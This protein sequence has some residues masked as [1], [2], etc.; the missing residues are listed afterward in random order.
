MLKVGMKH[1]AY[2]L[3]VVR[4]LFDWTIMSYLRHP[5]FFPENVAHLVETWRTGPQ[6]TNKKGPQ[7]QI[8]H[9]AFAP[10]HLKKKPS[11]VG[12]NNFLSY[13]HY[14]SQPLCQLQLEKKYLSSMSRLI[15]KWIPPKQW[16]IE[17]NGCRFTRWFLLPFNEFFL[18]KNLAQDSHPVNS[19]VVIFLAAASPWVNPN[20]P[21]TPPWHNVGM[22]FP[23]AQGGGRW[24]LEVRSC[25]FFFGGWSLK[26]SGANCGKFYGGY[27]YQ[28]LFWGN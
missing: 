13:L 24:K 20:R 10:C 5:V 22:E 15:S 27:R 18:Q 28:E 3:D 2:W 14:I 21:E 23:R 17:K 26:F 12:C 1:I 11:I 7:P 9:V 4:T 16:F 8:N 25:E 19:L 6:Q